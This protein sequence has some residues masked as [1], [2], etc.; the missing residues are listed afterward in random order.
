M[1]YILDALRKAERERGIKQVPTVMTNH[2]PR[3]VNRNR[4]WAILIILVMCVAVA[5]AWYLMH[6][7]KANHEAAKE[8]GTGPNMASN[9]VAGPSTSAAL[10]QP[11]TIQN[12]G[13]PSEKSTGETITPAVPVAIAPRDAPARKPR[14]ELMP[15]SEEDLESLTPDEIMRYARPKPAPAVS[16]IE[17]KKQAS[18]QEAIAKM[19]ISLL[20]FADAKEERMVFIDGNKYVE[21]DYVEGI[22]LLESI[23]LDGAILSYD[24]ERA[25]LQPKSK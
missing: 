23:T 12:S 2:A 4:S 10:L 13:P 7:Q 6:S 25:L 9:T 22:Y 20:M 18:L 14:V 11:S 21:G 3:T 16:D 15:L 1:S 17:Q 24:G 5:V 19:T 8:S